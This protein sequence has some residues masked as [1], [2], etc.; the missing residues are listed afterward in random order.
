M[1]SKINIIITIIFMLLSLNLTRV[2]ANDIVFNDGLIHNIDYY[3]QYDMAR[4]DSHAPGMK[5]TLNWLT[6]ARMYGDTIYV[7]ED[8][9]FNLNGGTLLSRYKSN[10]DNCL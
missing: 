10:K 8:G 3:L 9:I 2:K 6:G 1:R 5:T 4:V 7:N